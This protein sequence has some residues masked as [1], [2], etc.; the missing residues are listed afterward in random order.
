MYRDKFLTTFWWFF[1]VFFH[2]FLSLRA[3]L[4]SNRAKAVITFQPMKF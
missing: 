3:K 4:P 2:D 1:D